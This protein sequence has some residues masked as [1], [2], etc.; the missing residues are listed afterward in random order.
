MRLPPKVSRSTTA[1]QRRGSVKVLVQAVDT[2]GARD[3]ARSGPHA[4]HLNGETGVLG[5][6]NDPRLQWMR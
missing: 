6:S 2:H 5:L 1:A 4:A 3:G